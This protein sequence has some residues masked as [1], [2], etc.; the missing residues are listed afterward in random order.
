MPL[1]GPLLAVL[2]AGQNQKEMDT[3][4]TRYALYQEP[5]ERGTAQQI[6]DRENENIRYSKGDQ[7][8]EDTCFAALNNHCPLGVDDTA[9]ECEAC[10][11]LKWEKDLEEFEEVKRRYVEV[12][13]QKNTCGFGCDFGCSFGCDF[14]QKRRH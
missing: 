11:M 5:L 13:D 7:K 3:A 4:H 12:S 9:K 14:G 10:A 1:V 6:Y 2:V 8:Y